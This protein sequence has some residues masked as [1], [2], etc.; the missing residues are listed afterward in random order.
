MKLN[1]ENI[2]SARTK[3]SLKE[4]CAK[5]SSVRSIDHFSSSNTKNCKNKQ[6]TKVFSNVSFKCYA[7]FIFF[8]FY[9]VK[10]IRPF[11]LC[12]NAHAK[13]IAISNLGIGTLNILKQLPFSDSLDSMEAKFFIWLAVP[14][15]WKIYPRRNRTK[16]RSVLL[17]MHNLAEM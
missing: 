7:S 3:N 9:V 13:C 2:L 1:K 6:K 16:I 10:G 12:G 14:R 4:L 11:I 15:Y 5:S 17:Q 8:C